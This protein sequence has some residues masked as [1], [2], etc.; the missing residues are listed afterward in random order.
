MHLVQ[1]Y[2]ERLVL[3]KNLD[4]L[5]S[6]IL[7]YLAMEKSLPY[8]D[9]SF[10]I[11]VK[12]QLLLD[13]YDDMASRGT[14]GAIEKMLRSIFASGSVVEWFDFTTG[15]KTPG[16]FDISIGNEYIDQDSFARF[17]RI[18]KDAKNVSRHLRSVRE[19]NDSIYNSYVL[20]QTMLTDCIL[21]S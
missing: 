15:D 9:S 12:R 1:T 13:C 7:D 4:N 8:Y 17:V 2:T 18:L 20:T 19:N 5:P 21:I 14:T 3:H 11:D 6:N 10:S 16:Y